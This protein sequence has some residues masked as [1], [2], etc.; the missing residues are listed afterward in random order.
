MSININRRSSIDYL[1]DILKSHNPNILLVQET[2][3]SQQTL[4]CTL[5]QLNYKAIMSSLP[6][7]KNGICSIF[8]TD[9]NCSV[10]ALEPGRLQKIVCNNLIFYNIY[11]P[12]G[13]NNATSRSL[14]FQNNLF[15]HISLEQKLPIIMGDFN[16][17][18]HRIQ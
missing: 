15:N 11:A 17:V 14:F 7:A 4:D 3:V 1:V 13:S 16:C 8:K 5:K 6:D 12:S 2:C 18:E 9:Q 10:T